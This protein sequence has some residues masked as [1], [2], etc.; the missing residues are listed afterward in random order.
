VYLCRTATFRRWHPLPS[1]RVTRTSHGV[2]SGTTAPGGAEAAFPTNR[3]AKDFKIKLEHDQR[4]GTFVDP[5]LGREPFGDAASR[6]LAG[7]AVAPETRRAYQS[8][9][10]NHVLPALGD[11]AA[12][13]G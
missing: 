7:L 1:G 3:E 2:C 9:L 11:R 4:E 12:G 8:V 6:W 10:N 13:V 5:R